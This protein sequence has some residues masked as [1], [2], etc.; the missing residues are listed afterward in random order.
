MLVNYQD[1]TSASPS[2]VELVEEFQKARA[3]SEPGS[4]LLLSL[5]TASEAVPEDGIASIFLVYVY[6]RS[7]VQICKY[8]HM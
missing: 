5:P 1:E 3:R 8:V 4:R 7:S 2:Q 6:T